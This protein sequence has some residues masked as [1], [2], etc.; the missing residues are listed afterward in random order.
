MAPQSPPDKKRRRLI[1]L[2]PSRAATES[3]KFTAGVKLKALLRQNLRCIYS[4]E[5]LEG[6][7]IEFDHVFA[8]HLGGLSDL[9]NCVAT[10]RNVHG[11][12]SEIERLNREYPTRQS[13]IGLT[14]AEETVLRISR[15]KTQKIPTYGPINTMEEATLVDNFRAKLKALGIGFENTYIGVSAADEPKSCSE[16]KESKLCET[17]ESKSCETKESKS[18]ET[19]ESKSCETKESKSS[20]SARMVQPGFSISEI[21]RSKVASLNEMASTVLAYGGVCP[22]CKEKMVNP[23]LGCP[24]QKEKA[25]LRALGAIVD[26]AAQA[27]PASSSSSSLDAKDSK[28]SSAASESKSCSAAPEFRSPSA[29]TETKFSSAPSE[30]GSSSAANESKS[31]SAANEMKS[32]SAANE[33]KSSSATKE[34]KSISK[35]NESKSSSKAKKSKSFKTD[36]CDSGEESKPDDSDASADEQ[37]SSDDENEAPP[38]DP[39]GIFISENFYVASMEHYVEL[40]CGKVRWKDEAKEREAKNRS[41][42]P[43]TEH[44]SRVFLTQ[45]RQSCVT[46]FAERYP[47]FTPPS[48][49]EDDETRQLLWKTH[50]IFAKTEQMHCP[51]WP[52]KRSEWV[53]YGLMARSNLDQLAMCTWPPPK[54][55]KSQD[56]EITSS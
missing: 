39:F 21:N 22:Y 1:S 10:D 8:K 9:P 36:E 41:A 28:S 23:G 24:C 4:E 13:W 51:G 46:W 48:L 49:A 17:K 37:S 42:P 35:P 43:G 32:S 14:A 26:E 55:E 18:C 54:P 34:S 38:E 11:I 52:R 15:I 6:R 33:T 27:P 12:K 44:A 3:D 19:K 31:Q 29:A 47:Q 40:D 20:S 5:S 2:P 7:V 53:V 45:L 56:K 50:K 30:F 25:R 16:I